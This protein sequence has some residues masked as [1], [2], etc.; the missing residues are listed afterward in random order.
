MT[1]IKNFLNNKHIN[2]IVQKVNSIRNNEHINYILRKI[3]EIMIR[4]FFIIRYN[5]KKIITCVFILLTISVNVNINNITKKLSI[6]LFINGF[7]DFLNNIIKLLTFNNVQLTNIN[8]LVYVLEILLW[9]GLIY[10]LDKYFRLKNK[11]LK[12]FK[13]MKNFK[14]AEGEYPYLIKQKRNKVNYKILEETF[15]TNGIPL[16]DW[17]DKKENLEERLN[18]VILNDFE[19]I[20]G[21]K[22][23]ILVQSISPNYKVPKVIEWKDS[24]LTSQNSTLVLGENMIEKVIIDLNK[25]PHILTRR[26]YWKWKVC[27][28]RLFD[29]SML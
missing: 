18:R 14:N 24:S 2:N 5:W 28:G 10:I 23:K 25:T 26:K 16:K 11:H 13:K 7:A 12:H 15:Y 6:P 3:K 20:E 29:I 4:L 27:F 8:I 1:K 21:S 17:K 9:C 22:N 19:E